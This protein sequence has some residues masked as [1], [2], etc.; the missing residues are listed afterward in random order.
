MSDDVAEVVLF[1]DVDA[2]RTFDVETLLSLARRTAAVVVVVEVDTLLAEATLA[3]T[4]EELFTFLRSFSLPR[5][6]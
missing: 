1:V 5:A 4:L 2:P 6:T 3:A